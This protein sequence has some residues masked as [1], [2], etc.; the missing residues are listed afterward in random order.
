MITILADKTVSG[1]GQELFDTIVKTNG[2]TRYFNLAGMKIEP[3]YACRGCEEKTYGRCVIRDDADIILPSLCRSDTIIVFTPIVYGAYSFQ[4]KRAVDK[5]PLILDRH[6]YYRHGELVKGNIREVK[7]YAIGIHDEKDMEEIQI[8]RQFV[9]E[10][11]RIASWEGK[12]IVLPYDTDI[13]NSLIKE[14]TKI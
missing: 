4:V 3:C 6:Y 2:D 13:Y 7:Y 14:I 9:L 8:W 12:P 5:F 11:I 10:T 1:M